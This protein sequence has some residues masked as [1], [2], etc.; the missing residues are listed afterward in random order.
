MGIRAQGRG[1]AWWPAVEKGRTLSKT[2]Q[3]RAVVAALSFALG[4]A[5]TLPALAASEGGTPEAAVPSYI[6]NLTNTVA[7]LPF[8]S[9]LPGDDLASDADTIV[10][11]AGELVDNAAGGPVGD[12]KSVV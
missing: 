8:V 1:P 6:N 2:T 5:G 4:A 10:D 9:Y 11:D 7:D 3:R 12:R